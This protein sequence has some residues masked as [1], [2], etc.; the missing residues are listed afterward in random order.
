MQRLPD[1]IAL[2]LMAGLAPVWL[3]AGLADY[4][5]HRI[6]RIESNAGVRESVLHLLMLAELGMGIFVALFLQLTAAA[7]ALLVTACVAHE[8]TTLADLAYAESRRRIPWY[9]QWVHGLQQALPWTGLVL[10]MLV[11]APQALALFGLGS[12]PADWSLRWKDHPLPVAFV[13]GFPAAS[14]LMVGLPFAEEFARCSR[15][16]SARSTTAERPV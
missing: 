7:Y 16:L 14:V 9:E 13:A 8:L 2:V 15:R 1:L 10:L 6:Q 4:A 11:G 5:C 12:E 3:L